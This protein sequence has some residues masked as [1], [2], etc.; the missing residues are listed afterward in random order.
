MKEMLTEVQGVLQ[1][2]R[3]LTTVCEQKLKDAR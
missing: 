2:G 3:K 1:S